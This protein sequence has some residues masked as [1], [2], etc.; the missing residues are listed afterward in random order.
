MLNARPRDGDLQFVASLAEAGAMA[1]E[2]EDFHGK[3][4]VAGR[5]SPEARV[6]GRMTISF[7]A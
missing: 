4:S 7:S 3:V 6:W 5:Y 1:D 2:L